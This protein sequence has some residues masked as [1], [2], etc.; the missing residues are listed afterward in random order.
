MEISQN[1]VTS[2]QS[3][4][5]RIDGIEYIELEDR[6]HRLKRN[7]SLTNIISCSWKWYSMSSIQNQT[8]RQCSYNLFI[9]QQ[10]SAI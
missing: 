10:N 3:T 5:N 1:I 8:Q 2:I 9:L 7:V 6:I 4:Q